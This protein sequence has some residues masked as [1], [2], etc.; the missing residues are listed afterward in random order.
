[1]S[2]VSAVSQGRLS[3]TLRLA[4]G[5][6]IGAGLLHAALAPEHFQ[7]WW[8]YGSFFVVVALYQVTYG[9]ALL[10][11]RGTRFLATPFLASGMMVNA[12]LIGMY[13]VTRTAGVPYFGPL[14]GERESVGTLDVISKLME[15]GLVACAYMG[16]CTE[17]HKFQTRTQ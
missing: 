9:V 8:G 5:L 2:K 3:L 10:N 14:A 7:E 1:M 15:V 13:V 4:G 11:F 6:S 12:A 16:V 17:S